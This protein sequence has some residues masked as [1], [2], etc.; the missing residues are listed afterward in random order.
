MRETTRR[1]DGHEWFRRLRW[2][3]SASGVLLQYVYN[4]IEA[5][6]AVEG[7]C[8]GWFGWV[9]WHINHVGYFMPNIVYIYIYMICKHFVDNIFK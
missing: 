7:I 2:S 8:W 9:L 1:S 3:G 6:Q 4:M 5:V